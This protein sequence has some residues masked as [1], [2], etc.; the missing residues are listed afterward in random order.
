MNVFQLCLGDLR[1]AWDKRRE[2]GDVFAMY[3]EW[4]YECGSREMELLDCQLAFVA[5]RLEVNPFRRE[6]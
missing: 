6:R 1:L 5:I 4:K 3:R 2:W